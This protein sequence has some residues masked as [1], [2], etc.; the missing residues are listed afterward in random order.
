M[1][2]VRVALRAFDARIAALTQPP[3]LLPT[4]CTLLDQA[5]FRTPGHDLLPLVRAEVD[6]VRPYACSRLQHEGSAEWALRTLE[7]AL[8][9][10]RVAAVASIAA[11]GRH[12]SWC[13]AWSEAQRLALMADPK[14]N[15]GNYLATD[16]PLAGLAAARAIAMVTYRS[17]RAL[18]ARYA[19]ENGAQ[20]FGARAKRP[21]E[22]AVAGW[23]SHHGELL[24]ARFDANSYLRLL[25]AMDSHDIGRSRGGLH[26]ALA[27]ITQPVLVV[28][29]PSDALYVPDDQSALLGGL[30]NA[31]SATLDS[32]HG[33]DGFLIDAAALEP[34]VRDFRAQIDPQ[35]L[36]LAAG[37]GA[38][39]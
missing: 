37:R 18:N 7:W 13:I 30:P 36:S 28:S 32:S 39:P 5:S 27:A 26:A 25:E 23:L 19:R 2:L 38:Q 1:G 15:H 34:L 31:V 12:S 33:H 11:S 8:L 21:S 17:P 35:P 29:I 16:P 10:D 20:I 24:G 6:T 9:D 22:P 4:F 14:F 3:D